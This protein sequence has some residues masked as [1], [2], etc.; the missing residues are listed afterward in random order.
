MNIGAARAGSLPRSSEPRDAYG[1]VSDTGVGE[2]TAGTSATQHTL[3]T[4]SRAF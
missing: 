3:V 1:T 4:I 2:R